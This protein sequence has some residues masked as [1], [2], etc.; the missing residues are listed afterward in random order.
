MN[1]PIALPISA[2]ILT[3]P[4]L[5]EK[6]MEIKF[7]TPPIIPKTIL[8]FNTSIESIAVKSFS[9]DKFTI[10]PLPVFAIKL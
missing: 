4:L 3:F 5:N 10:A 1:P 9:W 6:I 8:N 2:I 7:K